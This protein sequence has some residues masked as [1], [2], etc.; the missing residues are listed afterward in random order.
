ME[1]SLNA[2]FFHPLLAPF[3]MMLFI[4]LY[5]GVFVTVLGGVS[6]AQARQSGGNGVWDF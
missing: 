1:K 2:F 3:S 4:Y 5:A 6:S